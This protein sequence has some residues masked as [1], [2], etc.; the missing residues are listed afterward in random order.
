MEEKIILMTKIYTEFLQENFKHFIAW[1]IISLFTFIFSFYNFLAIFKFKNRKL[2]EDTLNSEKYL[3]KSFLFLYLLFICLTQ[4]FQL[5]ELKINFTILILLTY[6]VITYSLQVFISFENYKQIKDPSFALRSYIN[7]NNWS[8]K[9]EIF[10]IILTAFSVLSCIF[11]LSDPDGSDEEK[12]FI[13]PGNIYFFT[14]LIIFSI[15]TIIFSIK[16]KKCLSIYT[17]GNKKNAVNRNTCELITNIFYF[18]FITY[19]L[20]ISIIIKFSLVEININL[21]L[22][23][24]LCIYFLVGISLIDSF[25]GSYSIYKSDFYY[26][27]LGNNNFGIFLRM[28]GKE[29]YKKPILSVDY[30][31]FNANMKENS[32]LY[33]HNTLSYMIEEH[34]IDTLDNIINITLA[35]LYIVFSGP[36]YEKS[37]LDLKTNTVTPSSR[38]FKDENIEISNSERSEEKKSNS[39]NSDSFFNS[40]NRENLIEKNHNDHNDQNGHNYQYL[41]KTD[42]STTIKNTNGSKLSKYENYKFFINDFSDEKLMRLISL[43]PDKDSLMVNGGDNSNKNLKVKIKSLYAGKFSEFMKK[44]NINVRAFKESLISHLNP[45]S[46]IWSSLLNK[47]SK[48]DYFKKQ[49][50]LL[51]ST[52][53]RLYSFEIC[54]EESIFNKESSAKKFLKKYFRHMERN[55]KT[56][57]PLILGVFKIQVNDFQELTIILTKNIIIQED[58]K[59]YY[60]YWQLIKIDR[61]KNMEMITSSKDRTSN[62]IR[63]EILFRNDFKLNLSDYQEFQKILQ[64]DLR[65]FKKMKTKEFNLLIMYYELGLGRNQSPGNSFDNYSPPNFYNENYNVPNRLSIGNKSNNIGA[66]RVSVISRKK[67]VPGGSQSNKNS[68]NDRKDFDSSSLLFREVNLIQLKENN[69]FEAN[70]NNF[71]CVLFFTFDNVFETACWFNCRKFSSGYFDQ[72]MGNFEESILK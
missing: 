51:L 45:S 58:P 42:F 53:D 55:N 16:K 60:N 66:I 6:L 56:F 57:L 38:N 36:N 4:V 50:K 37:E 46:A 54:G 23:N 17:V 14:P 20:T 49:K 69:G 71:K 47:N 61:E 7:E 26:Y 34:L 33:F 10:T 2:K 62:I 15:L 29:V 35:S 41:P 70:Y 19:L 32:V 22:F 52:Y 27:Y 21:S 59:E 13:H 24:L 9:Y 65:F 48:E 72:I 40:S 39:S 8:I 64:N 18:L 63:D 25:L 12:K 5:A 31:T 44:K 30:S 43:N 11:L 1:V 68:D 28:F 3:L 67:S